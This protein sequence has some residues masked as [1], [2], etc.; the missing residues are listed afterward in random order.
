MLKCSSRYPA[1]LR[2]AHLGELEI[3]TRSFDCPV[4]YSD[5]TIGSQASILACALGASLIEKH[6]AHKDGRIEIDGAFS[7]DF[8]ELKAI[9]EGV[10]QAWEARS[11]TNSV[12]EDWSERQ[13]RRSIYVAEDVQSGDSFSR[14]NVRIVRPGKGL[15]PRYWERVLNSRASCFIAKGTALTL[16]HLSEGEPSD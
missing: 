13:Y 8:N 15:H 1:E 2:A 7:A 4:G 12:R 10:Y 9:V 14:S 5:H 11:G 6:L 3:L 16:E